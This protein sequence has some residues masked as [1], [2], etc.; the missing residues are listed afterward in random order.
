MSKLIVSRVVS[1]GNSTIGIL[2][3]NGRFNSFTL[4]D[5]YREVKAP[6]ETRIPAGTYNVGVK[7][8]GRLHEKHAVRY[9]ELHKGML[10]V[11]GVVGFTDILIH[12]GNTAADTAGCLLVGNAYKRSDGGGPARLLHSRAAYKV[13]YN[14]VIDAALAGELTIEYRDDDRMTL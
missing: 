1:D 5:G 2:Y 9:G 13:L 11:Q 10:E 8:H 14:K 4:E 12:V 7:A 6:G 3:L